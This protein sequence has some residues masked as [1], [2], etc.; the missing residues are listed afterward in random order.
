MHVECEQSVQL[1]P[2]ARLE[3]TDAL[4]CQAELY[5]SPPRGVCVARL[6]FACTVRTVRTG[7]GSGGHATQQPKAQIGEVVEMT[8]R[9]HCKQRVPLHAGPSSLR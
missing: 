7:R 9:L 3:R 6:P 5:H 8:A 2:N 1:V 4:E